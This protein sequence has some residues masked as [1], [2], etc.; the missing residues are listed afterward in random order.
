MNE[1]DYENHG[2]HIKVSPLKGVIK[3]TLDGSTLAESRN[4]L[5]LKEDGYDKAY[6]IPLEDIRAELIRTETKTVCP[7]KGR[8]SY[9]SLKINNIIIEDALWQYADPKPE[10]IEL[11]NYASFYIKNIDSIKINIT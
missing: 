5:E 4:A 3:V 9:Y 1:I 11:N 10:F 2:H 8:A 7:Y 6:Y